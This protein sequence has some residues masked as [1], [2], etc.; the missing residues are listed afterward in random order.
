M[1]APALNEPQRPQ[2]NVVLEPLYRRVTLR[3]L[4]FLMLCY[5]A[6]FLDRVN[7]GFAKLQMLQDLGFSET[8]YGLG[9]GLFF[10]GYFVFEVPSNLMLHRFGARLTLMRIMVIWAVISAGFMFVRTP[11]QFFILR[12]LLGAAEAGFYPGI[13]L[14]LTRW[15]PSGRRAKIIALFITAIP[16][17]GIV[18]GPLSGWILGHTSH[19]GS[20]AG[21]QWLFIIEAVPSLILGLLTLFVLDD[22]ISAA[23]WLNQSEKN[24]LTA[25]LDAADLQ[26]GFSKKDSL[27]K[28]VASG[29]VWLLTVI[30]FCQGMGQYALSFWMPTLIRQA[31]ISDPLMV[32]STSA[33]PF[34]VAV[35]AMV[36][37]SRSSDARME[38]RWHLI[39]PFAVAA[40]GLLISTKVG[41]SLNAS[42]FALSIAA[43][44]CYCVSAMF[45]SIPSAFLSGAGAAGGIALINSFGSLA[46]FVS[47]FMVGAFKDATQNT[48]L[49][50][51]LLAATMVIGAILTYFLPSRIVNR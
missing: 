40:L 23:K 13:I 35:L 43:A 15:Y 41:G 38:R 8:I 29:Y 7:I 51:L 17:S 10:V 44:G 32:G 4:P 42:L 48:D 33:I 14:Y 11:T 49:P 9:A 24:L 28:A 5:V 20:L 1:S 39:V 12:F 2:S 18:G 22:S 21:W 6:A 36:L 37:V 45:W 16:I 31:G 50:M 47:P 46:G 30:C 25:E 34:T 26:V 27:L 19:W 3:L